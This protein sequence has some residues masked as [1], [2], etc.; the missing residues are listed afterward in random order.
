VT[1]TELRFHTVDQLDRGLAYGEGC[2]ETFRTV[3]GEV[4]LWTDHMQ[5]LCSGLAS[6]GC[7]LDD[8]DIE[9]IRKQVLATVDE[10]ALVR[11]TVTGGEAPW[12]LVQATDSRPTVYIQSLPFQQP[13]QPLHLTTVEWPF[14][15]MQK[16]AKLTS[17]YA[18]TLR[19]IRQWRIDKGKTGLICKDGKVLSALTA[20]VLILRDGQ[21]Y[22]PDSA[23]GGV[24]PGVVR[25]LLLENELVETADCPVS[26]LQEC[27]ALMLTNSSMFAKAVQSIDGREIDPLH[28]AVVA[29][30][31]LLQMYPGVRF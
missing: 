29:V 24:L 19:A 12:G 23:D 22:T 2:F 10:D 4:L 21:W 8:E 17:D 9:L 20:N 11:V 6:F 31:E 14:P 7:L 27:E 5:R 25:S 28:S 26:W 13:S 16:Q 1:K 3:D 15:L 18:S 30:Q